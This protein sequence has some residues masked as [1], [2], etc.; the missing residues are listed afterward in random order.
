M[1]DKEVKRNISIKKY[2]NKITSIFRGE[3][4]SVVQIMPY[5]RITNE[6][7]IEHKDDH[8]QA[9]LRVKTFDLQT[10]NDSELNLIIQVFQTLLKVYNEPLKFISLT[11]PTETKVQQ[12]F[13][14]KK[15]FQYSQR[16]QKQEKNNKA[17]KGLL[18]KRNRAM[19]E[20]QRM[21]WAES[22]L[23]DLTYF[24]VVYGKT[25]E[26]VEENIKTIQRLGRRRLEFEHIQSKK[27]LER[28]IKRLM[29]MQ[30]D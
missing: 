30:Q 23:K 1:G 24:L 5:K 19:D 13:Q 15:I 7:F 21:K 6:G 17:R 18:N 20:L 3:N 10:M 28:I 22:T 25:P 16:L 2:W 29:N 9:Y 27:E 4:L 26:E 11:Y 12:Y 14:K 8:Y